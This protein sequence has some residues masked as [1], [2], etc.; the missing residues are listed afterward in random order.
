MTD[1]VVARI[2]KAHGLKGEVTV[3]LHTDAPQERF[4][5]G[6]AFVTEPP[7]RGPLTLRS[8]R[9]HNGIQLLAFEEAPD[10][11]AAEQLRGTRLLAASTE[12]EEDEDGWYADDLVGLSVV[13]TGG[14]EIGRVAALHT[15]PAQD[16]LEI[17]KADGGRAYV[18]FVAEM[19]PEVDLEGGRV[20][21]DPPPGLLDLES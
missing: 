8:A 21:L 11:T 13:D 2:G 9:V 1:V 20:V 12:P 15:R 17:E 6:A 16:L 10:R 3:Q 18:P 4:V 5:P 7:E 19:V 14:A